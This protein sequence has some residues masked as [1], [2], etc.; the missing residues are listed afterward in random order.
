[1]QCAKVTSLFYFSGALEVILEIGRETISQI[2][3]ELGNLRFVLL[4][5]LL[6]PA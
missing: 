6:Q 1:V 2:Y 5:S 3:E 4:R